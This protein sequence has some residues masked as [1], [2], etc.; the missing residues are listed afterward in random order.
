MALIFVMNNKTFLVSISGHSQMLWDN[1]E[2]AQIFISY[3]FCDSW[4]GE[5]RNIFSLIVLHTSYSTIPCCNLQVG[6][7]HW[8]PSNAT[9]RSEDQKEETISCLKPFSWDSWSAILQ[10]IYRE[11]DNLVWLTMSQHN[12]LILLKRFIDYV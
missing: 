2:R 4:T 5:S 8:T 9:C 10:K 6:S 7:L 12:L 1:E 11:E 3:M